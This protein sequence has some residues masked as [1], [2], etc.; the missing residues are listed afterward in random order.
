VLA[1]DV[2]DRDAGLVHGHVGERTVPLARTD[3]RHPE[4][5]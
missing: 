2:P 3:L 5:P 1:E 4:L